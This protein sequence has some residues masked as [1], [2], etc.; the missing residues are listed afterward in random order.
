MSDTN[1]RVVLKIGAGS[2]A[3]GYAAAV[4]I[5]EEGTVPQV[6]IQARLS[7]APDLPELYRQWQQ[8]YWQ[9]GAAYRIQAIEGVTNV[10]AISNAEQCQT[11]SRQLRDRVHHWLNDDAFR[12]IRE[13][14][15]EQLSA[16]D[17]T[18]IL[19]QTK[20]PLLQ[21]LPWYEL[22]FFDRYRR[23]EVGICSPDYQQASYGGTRSSPVRILAVLG[24]GTGLDTQTDRALLESLNAEIHVLEE[25]NRETF[26]RTLWDNQG[27]DILFFAGHSRSGA[28]GLESNGELFLNEQDKLTIPQL[29]HALRKA[30]DRGL[31][32]AIF[33]SCDGLGLAAD[34]CD[35]HIPQVLVMRELV[36]DRVAHAFLQGFLE[37]FSTGS[38]F[39]VAVREARE[40]LQGLEADYP[41][42]TWLPVIVQNMAET[43][44]TW[45][46]LQGQAEVV[47][48]YKHNRRKSDRSPTHSH[49][50]RLK[51]GIGS[52]VIAATLL[53]L[54]RQ[55]GLLETWELSAYDRLLPL[56][57][58]ETLDDR[59]L[60][61]TNTKADAPQQPNRNNNES[62]SEE[63]LASVLE[64]L[65]QLEPA[66][67]GLDIYRSQPA[68]NPALAKQLQTINNLVGI[69]KLPDETTGTPGRPPSPEIAK[70]ESARAAANDFVVKQDQI[71][72]RHLVFLE[73]VPGFDCS[74]VT[75]S[76]AV[77]ERYLDA[78]GIAIATDEEEQTFIIGNTSLPRIQTEQNT[79]G[80]YHNLDTHGIQTLLN[81]RI[82]AGSTGCYNVNGRPIKETPA[83]CMSVSDFLAYDSATLDKDIRGRIILIGTTD[84]DYI[85]EDSWLTPYTRTPILKDQVPGV[86]LQAQMV[87]QL[88][89]AGID[90]RSFLT[91]WQENQEI[92]WIASWTLIGGLI[93]AF[94]HSRW[95]YRLWLRLVMAE[96]LLLLTCWLWLAKGNLWVP[97]IPSAIALPLS[98]AATQ[99]ALKV[100]DRNKTVSQLSK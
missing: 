72:R 86:F 48:K 49:W 35:L 61:L 73:E 69:C 9:L 36:P 25:P 27:W 33:N 15:L 52:S 74:G 8:S 7:P 56:R 32:T 5:G 55:V 40:K 81:Y 97:W 78:Q 63:T 71:L 6:E 94:S 21:R 44:P 88:I 66:V 47:A 58:L 45:Y 87:S 70:A 67:I 100:S 98:A 31:N 82:V 4:Q 28:C 62:W 51:A 10:S 75:F 90:N 91:S 41:C 42:A 53:I 95:S 59:I 20:D 84:P 30:I 60:I 85:P 19:L 89:S 16:Q 22:Q 14:L 92:I 17:T 2:L 12:P 18:R 39:Y 76:A 1:K 34:L 43:P 68:R 38:P 80:G 46:S 13:K 11:L 24:N 3:I 29:K 23:A 93:G 57:S 50:T 99:T 83:D 54:A 65:N 79:F 37:S 77:A 26:N 96:G 64:K